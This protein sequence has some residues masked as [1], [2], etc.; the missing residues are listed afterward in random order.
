M[1]APIWKCLPKS[2]AWLSYWMHVNIAWTL[3]VWLLS[4]FVQLDFRLLLPTAV[5][6]GP[7]STPWSTACISVPHLCSD[8]WSCLKYSSHPFSRPFP[9]YRLEFGPATSKKPQGTRPASDQNLDQ[10]NCK[11][12]FSKTLGC[13]FQLYI[14]EANSVCPNQVSGWGLGIHKW[15]ILGDSDIHISSRTIFCFLS[16]VLQHWLFLWLMC[17]CGR[18]LSSWV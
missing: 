17:L 18:S 3:P 12:A 15:N 16:F 11:P 7:L 1:Q 9:P 6:E 8:A 14:S 4:P 2:W 5:I 13:L 10:A